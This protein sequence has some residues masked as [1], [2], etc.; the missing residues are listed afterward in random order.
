VKG[1]GLE[2]AKALLKANVENITLV[3]LDLTSLED[4][5][6]KLQEWKDKIHIVA[7]DCSKDEDTRGYVDET[8]QKFGKLDVSFSSGFQ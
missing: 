3:D 7:A 5:R 4:A 2:V 1:I 8:V 6:S